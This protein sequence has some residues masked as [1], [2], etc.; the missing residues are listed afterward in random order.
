MSSELEQI[1]FL[2]K[3][4]TKEWEDLL[5]SVNA[6]EKRIR[7]AK[8]N[9]EFAHNI[10]SSILREAKEK[11]SKYGSQIPNYLITKCNLKILMGIDY[12]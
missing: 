4:L 10:T 1:F 12:E 11:H 7:E 6:F 2:N 5:R 3:D 9:T 8:Y